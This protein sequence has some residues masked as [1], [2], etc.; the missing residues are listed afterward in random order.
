MKEKQINKW[1]K[2][3][4]MGKKKFVFYYGV[5]F[6]GLLT[7]LLFPVIGLILFNKSLSLER[8]IFSLIVFPLGGILFGLTMWHS[9]EKKYQKCKKI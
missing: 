7:G 8:F 6:W 1:G 2:T 4:Q 3:R 9:S 5:L